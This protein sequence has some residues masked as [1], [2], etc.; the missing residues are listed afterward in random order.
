M[1]RT[2]TDAEYAQLAQKLSGTEEG[3]D[4]VPNAQAVAQLKRVHRLLAVDGRQAEELTPS[5]QLYAKAFDSAPLANVEEVIDGVKTGN[6]VP[7]VD[8]PDAAVAA[9][10]PA[11]VEAPKPEPKK[12]K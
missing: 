1:I 3:K 12:E 5:E 2:L 6:L 11:K 10:A 9:K 7:A 4:I 8:I